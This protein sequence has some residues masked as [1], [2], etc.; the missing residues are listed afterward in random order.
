MKVYNKPVTP[1]NVA[2]GEKSKYL[3]LAQHEYEPEE[4]NELPLITMKPGERK[5]NVENHQ[6]EIDQLIQELNELRMREKKNLAE[7]Q[8]LRSQV[9]NKS[10][11]A[12]KAETP[13]N[14]NRELKEI[15]TDDGL[16]SLISSDFKT[17]V[18]VNA[19]HDKMAEEIEKELKS[20]NVFK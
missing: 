5:P 13:T 17:D 2:K 8:L 11:T 18:D 20:M 10:E 12:K 1:S 4:D 9:K 14:T 3:T 7:I 19:D 15:I 16:E 6:K